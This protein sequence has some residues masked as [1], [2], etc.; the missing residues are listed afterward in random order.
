MPYPN[1]KL[2]LATH[3]VFQLNL[4]TLHDSTLPT[5]RYHNKPLSQSC[6]PTNAIFN[7]QAWVRTYILCASPDQ[8]QSNSTLP[9]MSPIPKPNSSPTTPSKNGDPLAVPFPPSDLDQVAHPIRQPSLLYP[10]QTYNQWRTSTCPGLITESKQYERSRHYAP[11]KASSRTQML[12][13]EN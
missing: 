5:T 12:S 13:K 10:H 9:S 1:S 8:A 2:S 11:S 6:R 7:L 3:P 4:V